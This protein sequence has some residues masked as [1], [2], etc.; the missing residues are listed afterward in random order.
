MKRRK[1]V[2][3][4]TANEEKMGDK[5]GVLGSGKVKEKRIKIEEEEKREV[6]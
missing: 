6:G 1:M 2:Q 5:K 3:K 4:S